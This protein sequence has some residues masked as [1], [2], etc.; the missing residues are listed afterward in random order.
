MGIPKF[1]L[2]EFWKK[3]EFSTPYLLCC[4]DPESWKM[5]ELI[6]MADPECK[7]M[8]ETLT[9]G[10]TEVPGMPILRKEISKLYNTINQEDV[11][12]FAGAEEGIYCSLKSLL[13]PSDHVIVFEP[14]YQS[15]KTIPESCGAEISKIPLEFENGWQIDIN[16]VKVA[17]K[18]NTKLIILNYPHNPTGTLIKKETL[19]QIIELA[20]QYNAYI[21]SDEVYR[22]LEINEK[23]R[24]LSIADLYEKGIALNVMS[25]SF[26]LP[27]LRVGWIVSKDKNFIDQISS[28]KVYTSICNSAPSEV[29]ALIALRA[30]KIII[31][32]NRKIMLYNLQQLDKFIERNK[33]LVTWQR[34][35]SGT[36]GI[37]KVL[38]SISTDELTKRLSKDYG[39]L[40]MPGSV[41]DLQDDYF[42]IG[43]GRKNMPEILNRFE[44]AFLEIVEK[45]AT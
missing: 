32:R 24:E 25:K 1:K 27:G 5:N 8:W 20:K 4:S 21:F 37:M 29:L 10:Y 9:L 28:Y 13:T 44:K 3:Y 15:L 41:I 30:K 43:F 23:T 11:I 17:M 12:T 45:V 26:G 18:K 39:I 2:E 42:R 36:I 31:E 35:Q 16:K 38:V 7:N 6:E 40:I 22:F 34:P 19:S 14:C 33:Q